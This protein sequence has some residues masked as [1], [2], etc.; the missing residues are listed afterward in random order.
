MCGI[1]SIISKRQGG[2][3]NADLEMFENLLILDTLRGLD[4]TGVFCVDSARQVGYLKVASHPFHLFAM[5]E[6][7]KWRA[8]AIQ[9]GRI[10]VGHNRKATQG[11]IN[12]KNAHPFHS[13]NIVLVHNGTLRGDHKK[14]FAPVDVD[15][16]ALAIAFDENGAENVIP[17]INGAF[18]LIWWDV[19]KNRLFAIRNDE[20][21][22]EIVETDDSFF[23]LSESW[24]ALQLLAKD[25]KKVTNVTT[26]EPGKLYEFQIGGKHTIKDIEVQK[27]YWANNT[28]YHTGRSRYQHG[29]ASTSSVQNP[30]SQP[31]SSVNP[32]DGGHQKTSQTGESETT[33]ASTTTSPSSQGQSSTALTLVKTSHSPEALGA[34]QVERGAGE[35]KPVAMPVDMANHVPCDEFTRGMTVLV[36]LYEMKLNDS[37]ELYFCRGKVCEPNTP[38]IDVVTY[39]KA[40]DIK[41]GDQVKYLHA[42]TEG[43]VVKHTTSSCGRSLYIGKVKLPACV[44]VH[45][46]RITETE[47][48]YITTYC[49]CSTCQKRIYDDDREYTSIFRRPSNQFSVTCAD[50]VE[51]TL[52]GEEKHEFTQNRLTSLQAYQREC[53]EA[54]GSTECGPQ[55][56]SSSSPTLH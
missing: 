15:S 24:M 29:G 47:W 40:A 27:D 54:T 21:P 7:P 31:S 39:I 38:E 52:K 14:D 18:A 9:S 30:K 48:N 13:G 55:P 12:S 35:S 28:T 50:C 8:R 1:V 10:L 6:Y 25:R 26:I 56:A 11:S 3:W 42:P 45:N 34:G 22:L 20:R 53:D 33:Q 4:S 37:Q 43:V 44:N 46:N 36:K 51:E 32:T 41:D 2:F 19:E 49:K 23:V 17:K 5:Q 16:H